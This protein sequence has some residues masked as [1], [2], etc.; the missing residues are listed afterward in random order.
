M[1]SNTPSSPL[2]TRPFFFSSE[3]HVLRRVTRRE[4]D[5]INWICKQAHPPCRQTDPVDSKKEKKSA[6]R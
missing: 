6:A 2:P 1:C 5:D 4:R 3:I